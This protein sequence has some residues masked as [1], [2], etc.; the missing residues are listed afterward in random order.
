MAHHILHV[1][2]I[3]LVRDLRPGYLSVR[4]AD[5]SQCG[6]EIVEKKSWIAPYSAIIFIIIIII[7]IIIAIFRPFWK[8]QLNDLSDVLAL[9]LL[10][11]KAVSLC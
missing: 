9:R 6:E 3:Q 8:L 1:T 7:I 11:K 2:N 4:V 10:Q 5:S